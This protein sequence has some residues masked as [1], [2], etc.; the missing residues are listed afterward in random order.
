VI[1]HRLSTIQQADR[2]L[3]VVDGQ[4]VEEG[5]HDELLAHNAQ[6]RKLYDL[7]FH[8]LSLQ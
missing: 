6:Y 5:R 4:I 2:I 8:T 1:A 7:Q 3:V